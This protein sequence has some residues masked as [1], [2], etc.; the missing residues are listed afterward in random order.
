MNI[1]L[2]CDHRPLQHM[3]SLVKHSSR[4]ARYAIILQNYD[5][6]CKYVKGTEQMA[7][8]LTIECMTR[9]HVE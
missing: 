9:L 1:D 3:N 5:I 7:D 6:N 4:L 8:A 2:L